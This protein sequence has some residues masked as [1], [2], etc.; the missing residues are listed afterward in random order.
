MALDLVLSDDSK[1]EITKDMIKM[2]FQKTHLL[3]D[4]NGEGNLY[5]NIYIFILFMNIKNSYIIYQN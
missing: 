3:Y 1:N 4:K 2:S 5:I